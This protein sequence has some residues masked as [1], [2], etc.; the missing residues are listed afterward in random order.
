[1]T[2]RQALGTT[3][4]VPAAA[5]ATP[6][7]VNAAKIETLDKAIDSSIERQ[8][9]DKNH[10]YRGLFV[11]DDGLYY[12]G[13]CAGM[14]DGFLTALLSPQSRHHKSA[15]VA[16][17]LQL[18]AECFGRMQT[19]DGN[20]NLPLTNFNSPPDTA[21]ILQG[22]SLTLMN[23]RQYGFPDLEQWLLPTIQ[24]AGD[25]LAKGGM[26]T[27]N[28]RWVATSALSGLYKLYGEA[29]YLKRAEQWLAEGID[30]DSDG[31]YTERSSITY[32]AISNRAL[33]F[34]AEWL[35]RPEYLAPVRRNLAAMLYLLHADGEVVTEISRRQD[36]NL[37]GTLFYH[38]FPLSYLAWKDQNGQLA[39]LARQLEPAYGPVS[40]AMRWPELWTGLPANEPLPDNFEKIFP[41]IGLARIRRGPKS[42]GILRDRDRFF[43]FRHGG[44]VVTAV[45][46]AS[47][48][49]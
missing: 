3:L 5:A 35:D 37:R 1:M 27:P 19:R 39:T 49:F 9:T 14:M 36:L 41:I 13:T 28:H 7:P 48:F 26:H 8:I 20:W 6:P 40:Y 22:L 15:R 25:G 10:K 24:R 17:R 23:A 42:I 32:N 4:L 34:I 29:K 31:Q 44:A 21:F 38:W 12:A 18:T 45:R 46:I 43:T 30:I 11:A 2:R 33:T 16:E 47:A